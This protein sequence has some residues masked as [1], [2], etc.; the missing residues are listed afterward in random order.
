VTAPERDRPS[1]P[2]AVGAGAGALTM[3][4]LCFANGLQGG[5]SQTFA[6]ATEALKHAYHINDATLGI[7]PFGVSIAGNI[8]AIPVAAMCAKHRRTYV[9]AGMFLIWGVFI[10]LA[11][12][13]PSFALFGV[14]SAGFA[15]F[16]LFRVCSSFMEATDPA[17]LP[18]IADWYPVEDRAKKVSVF[19]TLSAVG[20]ILGLVVAGILID[21]IGW[22]FAFLM[23]PPLALL[24][25]ILIRSRTEP[26]RGAQDAAYSE[27]L[28]AEL[29]GEE[30][31]RVIE[32]VEHEA[33][34]IAATVAS[35]LNAGAWATLK[36]VART[37]S[38]R[39]TAIGIAVSGLMGT[40]IMTWGL[41][42][43]KRTFGLSSAQAGALAPVLGVGA[44]AGVLGGGF[45]A[46]R[47]LERGMVKA[48]LYVTA[49]GFFGAGIVYVLA[50]MST[51]LWLAAP[52]L[53]VASAFSTIPLG[54]QYALLM[55][56]TPSP[57]RSQAS[58]ALNILQ[59]TG[60]LGP[61]VV[62]ILS[63]LF[64]E[65]LRLALLCVS[66]FYVVGAVFVFFAQR[67]YVEDMAI[68]VAD[69]KAHV[70]EERP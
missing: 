34:E 33:A 66:P 60:A 21:T 13:S 30:K 40:G 37:R 29:E 56:V 63:T 12:L 9:L 68:V 51:S 70:E 11:G 62:G 5:A 58:A 15:V 47:L 45:L 20:S 50:F 48:R 27:R 59:A 44:F 2:V 57:L 17:A 10:L 16:A 53:A 19:N 55:D 31:E 4:A 32:L 46:D 69:A 49:L 7:V 24:G 38:W 36:S 64:G 1:V 25:A 65:N 61:L 41:A 18:L 28:E 14:A 43:F 8:G 67:T 6:Q 22:R 26:I 52:L 42:Y 3:V 39:L 23:W 35:G 54:P